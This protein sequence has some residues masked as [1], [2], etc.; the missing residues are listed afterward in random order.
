[1]MSIGYWQVLFQAT[2]RFDS[3]YKRGS[4]AT[5]KP[6]SL[7]PGFQ[8]A[9]DVI[10]CDTIGKRCAISVHVGP[11]KEHVGNLLTL[12]LFGSGLADVRDSAVD[13]DRRCL[14]A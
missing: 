2:H 3:S 14:A 4:P 9:P 11:K 7:M 6:A 5:F 10:H 8:E 1:M 13:V 12:K